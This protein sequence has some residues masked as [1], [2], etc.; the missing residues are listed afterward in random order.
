MGLH[1]IVFVAIGSHSATKWKGT[2]REEL[3]FIFEARNVGLDL[4][5]AVTQLKNISIRLRQESKAGEAGRTL[6]I[7]VC[8]LMSWSA[9]KPLVN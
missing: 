4:A 8:N 6:E 5:I 9:E 7:H 3:I 2:K 1:F